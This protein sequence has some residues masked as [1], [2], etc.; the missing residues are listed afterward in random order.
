M[1]VSRSTAPAA[2]PFHWGPFRGLGEPAAGRTFPSTALL[3]LSAAG[4]DCQLGRRM[5]REM[6]FCLRAREARICS[7]RSMKELKGSRSYKAW[8]RIHL[9]T[10][11]GLSSVWCRLTCSFPA[12]TGQEGLRNLLFSGDLAK[13]VNW[14]ISR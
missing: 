11:F 10:S 13:V 1:T 3:S 4:I 2:H 6:P 14:R 9:R 12:A 8:S 5:T 7:S